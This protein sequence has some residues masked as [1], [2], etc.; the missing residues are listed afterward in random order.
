VK[1]QRTVTEKVVAANRSNGRNKKRP[2]DPGVVNQNARKH[3]LLARQLKFGSA[4]QEADFV[5]LLRGF[6]QEYEPSGATETALVEEAAVCLW[7]L[8]LLEGWAMEEFANRRN[9]AQALVRAVAENC[10]DKQLPFFKQGNG[11][12]SPAQLGWDC[13][14]L[15]IRS[16]TS[17]VE[18]EDE[19][20]LGVSDRR[21]TTCQVLIAAKLKSSIDT[22]G[23]YQAAFKKDF[24]RA[25]AALRDLRR[26]GLGKRGDIS[27]VGE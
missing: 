26:E 5:R 27:A 1:V 11:S 4:E 2:R 16:G 14:E 22:I 17:N 20:I 6:E 21:A 18:D 15:V 19:D 23:R 13:E 3:G 8:G 24:Y 10:D 25:I 12:P 9:A 7:K